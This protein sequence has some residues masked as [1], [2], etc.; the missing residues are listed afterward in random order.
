[1]VKNQILLNK[2]T[3]TGNVVESYI[4]FRKFIDFLEDKVAKDKSIRSH[5][6]KFALD[7]IKAIP[8]L[9]GGV[10]PSE[11]LKYDEIL[12]LIASI[13]VPMLENENE[14]LVALTNGMTP[15]VF[16][17]TEAFNRLFSSQSLIKENAFDEEAELKMLRQTQYEVILQEFYKRNLSD[18]VEMVK[19][20]VD[21]HT[22][23]YK[24]FRVNIDTRFL[25]IYF[26]ESCVLANAN[27]I[28]MNFD[29]NDH[30]S[31]MEKLLPLENFVAKGFGILT[32]TDVTEKHAIEQLGKIILNTDK[33]N[34]ES[35]FSNISKLFQ[36]II[37]TTDYQVGIMPFLLINDRAALPYNNFPYSILIKAAAEAG[38]P[39]R[40]FSRYISH[41]AQNPSI[42]KYNKGEYSL[43][44]PSLQ[45][46]L[47]NA[48]YSSYQLTPVYF[49]D[50]LVGII[51]IAAKDGAKPLTKLQA[52]KLEPA[53]PYISQL[54]KIMIEKFDVSIDRIVKERFTVIQPAVQ[55]KFNEV[56]W[57]YFRSHDIEHTDKP[58]EKIS[59]ESVYPLY[60]AIDI[61]NSTN[62]RNKALREDL[63]YH[64]VLLENLLQQVHKHT[65]S[66]ESKHYIVETFSWLKRMKDYVSVEDELT[67]KEFLFG[68]VSMFLARLKDL[69]TH[70]TE[71]IEQYNLAVDEATGLAFGQRR[72]FETS[73]QTINT[74]IGK[75]LEKLNQSV[76]DI[77]PS[78]FEKFRTDG[79]EYDIYTGQSIAPQ[80][81]FSK[82]KLHSIR[83]LQLKSM[84]VIAKQTASLAPSLGYHLQTT[85]LIFVN[86]KSIDISFRDDEKRF[87]VEGAYNIRYQV[88]KKRI[89]KV[90]IKNTDERLTQPNKIAIVYFNSHDA[91]EFEQYIHQLQ[92]EGLLENNLE[93]LELQ[94]LQGVQG[95]KALRVGVVG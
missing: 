17:S 50:K 15:E 25:N 23:L 95:L 54:L 86:T 20:F 73:M 37:G 67:L 26:K 10:C 87:D 38:V 80:V 72:K 9:V 18:K 85:Q 40:V 62:E 58:F 75:Y 93:H 59:F 33:E 66:Q 60:G 65:Q 48:G 16:Y 71:Q 79:I 11:I 56:A 1:M 81:L 61:R 7:K 41:Y 6:Y 88:I 28:P 4:C 78:Y 91:E 29:A 84:A 83:L 82:E 57:H 35:G 39:K 69:P 46:A 12:E 89:D 92:A 94:A 3:I 90:L 42:I 43:M 77:Y 70:I 51:E 64:L 19:Q 68:E 36:T 63:E 22:G 76:Q 49:N 74:T 8:E 13:V 53:Y 30:F 44:A 2:F 14:A 45:T 21:E 52:Q 34:F 47:D 27:T 32:L 5:F 24:Y 55:W 31:E